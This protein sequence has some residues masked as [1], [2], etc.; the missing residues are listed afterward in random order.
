MPSNTNSPFAI[1][2]L[3]KEALDG[4]AAGSPPAALLQNQAS[5]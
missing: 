5:T 4:Q 1:D 2:D 3:T